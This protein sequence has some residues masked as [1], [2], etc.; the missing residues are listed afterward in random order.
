MTDTPPYAEFI[1]GLKYYHK[2]LT[3]QGY[4]KSQTSISDH[5]KVSGTGLA[6]PP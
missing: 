4:L 2:N 6:L 3:D 1:K 5:D